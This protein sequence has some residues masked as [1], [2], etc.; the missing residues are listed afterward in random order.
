MQPASGRQARGQPGL[1][2]KCF[3]TC[4]RNCRDEQRCDEDGI[5]VTGY[6]VRAV[7]IESLFSLTEQSRRNLFLFVLVC[8]EK[9]VHRE[10]FA[11]A[12]KAETVV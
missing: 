11:V 10:V 5:L 1:L 12:H 3:Q 7:V 8:G 9:Q 4:F 2:G 6:P